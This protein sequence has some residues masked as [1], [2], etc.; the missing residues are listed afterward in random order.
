[1]RSGFKRRIPNRLWASASG[2]VGGGAEVEKLGAP[3]DSRVRVGVCH[4][5]QEPL[6]T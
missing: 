3:E 2:A 6:L 5:G 4:A 1:M